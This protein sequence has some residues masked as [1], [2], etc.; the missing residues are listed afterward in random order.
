M[1]G[2]MLLMTSCHQPFKGP[3]TWEE[4]NVLT[5]MFISKQGMK[6]SPYYTL[7]VK[8]DKIIVKSSNKTPL[9]AFMDG[10][11]DAQKEIGWEY[12]YQGDIVN[13]YEQ[14]TVRELD[15]SQYQ[16]IMKIIEKY[17]ALGWDGTYQKKHHL[18]VDKDERFEL[19]L[20]C[21]NQKTVAMKGFNHCPE[22]FNELYQE[23]ISI[24]E[25]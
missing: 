16:D 13:T 23:F 8:G 19:Y 7:V 15:S 24:I 14:A 2:F 20:Q 5:G 17:G 21:S 6:R 10:E 1:T 25:E 9:Q 12:L 11:I 4:G 22:G 3:L 18:V